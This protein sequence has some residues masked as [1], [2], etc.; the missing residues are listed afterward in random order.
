MA[1]PFG[2]D[3]IQSGIFGPEISDRIFVIESA[4]K[5]SPTIKEPFRSITP[6]PVPIKGTVF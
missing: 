6:L 3:T 4:D 2:L 1:R 5:I